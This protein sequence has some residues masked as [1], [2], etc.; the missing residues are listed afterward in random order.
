LHNAA[1]ARLARASAR[2]PEQLGFNP[3]MTNAEEAKREA[4][5]F[6]VAKPPNGLTGR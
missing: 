2:E 6:D 5:V 4:Q 3:K 1:L